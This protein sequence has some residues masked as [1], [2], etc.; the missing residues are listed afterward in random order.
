MQVKPALRAC[1]PKTVKTYIHAY[2]KQQLKL[3]NYYLYTNIYS[4]L[5][6]LIE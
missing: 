3:I 6:L 2:K 5:Q 1:G 4:L